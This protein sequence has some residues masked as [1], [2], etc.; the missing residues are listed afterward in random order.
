VSGP[1]IVT[2][3]IGDADFNWLDGLRRVHFPAER[4]IL[5]AHLTMFHHLPPSAQD[6][7]LK[8][9]REE[10]KEAA[11]LAHLTAVM[12]LGRGV[13]F[14]VQSDGL[15]LARARLA[16]A[17]SLT[18]TPQDQAGWHPHITI[19]NKVKPDEARALVQQLSANFRPRGL[20]ITGLAAW[21][22]LDGPWEPIAAY[23]FG[24]G[25]SM[26]PPGP[27]RVPEPHSSVSR[28][29]QRTSTSYRRASPATGSMWRSSS[30]G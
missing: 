20:G 22:Y 29:D 25:R 28:V 16:E 9:L 18:L 8:R 30:A 21:R 1:I 2:A 5:R 26:K 13:A 15:S 3:L 14:A 23:R 19:Q 4:N 7:L 24:S 17:F 27:L 10:T 11:P 12:S 6:E